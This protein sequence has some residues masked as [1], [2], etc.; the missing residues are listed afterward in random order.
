MIVLKTALFFIIAGLVGIGFASRSDRKRMEAERTI[1][2]VA[3]KAEELYDLAQM[4]KKKLAD[5]VRELIEENANL[6]NQLELYKENYLGGK[7]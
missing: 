6:R 7:K 1:E 5:T 3:E 4:E 2:E